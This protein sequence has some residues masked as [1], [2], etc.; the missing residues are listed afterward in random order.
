MMLLAERSG[1]GE[2]MDDPALDPGVYARVL[3]DL[4]RVNRLT[5]AYRPTLSF[6]SRAAHTTGKLRLLDVGFGQGDMLRRIAR[7]CAVNGIVADLVGVDLNANSVSVARARTPVELPIRYL[8]GDYADLAGQNF[9]CIVSSLVAHHMTQAE[10]LRFLTF[11]DNEAP[12]GWFIND[13]RRS[14]IAWMGFPLLAL[15]AGAHPIVR[16]DGMTSIARSFRPQEWQG[17]LKQAGVTGATVKRY[18]PFRLCVE[19]IC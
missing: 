18:F 16:G 4:S 14:A 12:A 7:W 13:L 9:D 2:Q 17:M 5:L 19:K 10:L 11:M 3:A 1:A 8:T 6:L 15:A